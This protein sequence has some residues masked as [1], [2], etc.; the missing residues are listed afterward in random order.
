MYGEDYVLV[1]NTPLNVQSKFLSNLF[2]NFFLIFFPKNLSV[3]Y[4]SSAYFN[5]TVADI[6][7]IIN[8]SN[9]QMFTSVR[10]AARLF[11]RSYISITVLL[12]SK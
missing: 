7:P 9:I 2:L 5:N 6:A 4:C 12:S 3:K 10:G 8:T 11:L 1:S